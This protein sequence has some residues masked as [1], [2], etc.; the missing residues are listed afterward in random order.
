MGQAGRR[1]PFV[2]DGLVRYL[3]VE[4]EHAGWG[5][6]SG[7]G[8]LTLYEKMWAFCP[9]GQVDGH[10]WE[11]IDGRSIADIRLFPRSGQR[12]AVGHR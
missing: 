7:G 12:P 5:R 10:R 4:P 9:F 11:P 2:S 8:V 1:R 3:C 6:D